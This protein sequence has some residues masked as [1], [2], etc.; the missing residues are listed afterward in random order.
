MLY[1]TVKSFNSHTG[2][3]FI[4]SDAVEGDVYAHICNVI[5][6]NVNRLLPNQKVSFDLGVDHKHRRCATN[7]KLVR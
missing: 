1:G 5:E 2:Y 6:A 3:G 7:I 4:I